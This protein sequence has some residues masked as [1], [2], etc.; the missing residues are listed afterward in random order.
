MFEKLRTHIP[1]F[2]DKVSKTELKGGGYTYRWIT[3]VLPLGPRETAE[4]F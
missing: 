3:P 1:A 2:F 4:S